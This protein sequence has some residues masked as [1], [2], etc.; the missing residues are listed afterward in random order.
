[1]VVGCAGT[2]KKRSHKRET[3]SGESQVS[4]RLAHAF[5]GFRQLRVVPKEGGKVTGCFA[6][7]EKKQN[8]I[9]G[10][11]NAFLGTWR[12]DAQMVKFAERGE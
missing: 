6:G 12:E 7:P 5:L 2:N 3:P 8:A 10:R 4:G 9:Q 1:M 11:V